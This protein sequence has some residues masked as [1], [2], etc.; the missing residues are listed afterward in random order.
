MYLPHRRYLFEPPHPSGNSNTLHTFLINCLVGQ[1]PSCTMTRKFQS[2]LCV[3]YRY[4]PALKST[5]LSFIL[6]LN[7]LSNN[8]NLYHSVHWEHTTWPAN[9]CLR[10]IVYSCVVPS[11]C[12]LVQIIFCSC[13]LKTTPSCEKWQISFLSENDLNM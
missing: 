6:M 2:L 3:E 4:F 1:N 5:M 12:I 13:I 7:E 11:K 9:N 10:I 8:S